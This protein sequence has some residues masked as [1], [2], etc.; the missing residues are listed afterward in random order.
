MAEHD[1]T[2]GDSVAYFSP[3]GRSC[4]Y[5]AT[6]GAAGGFTP[7]VVKGSVYGFVVTGTDAAGNYIAYTSAGDGTAWLPT[8]SRGTSHGISHQ[9]AGYREIWH[10]RFGGGPFRKRTRELREPRRTAYPTGC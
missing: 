5:S 1:G 3:N 7:Q 9:R 2:A 8:G 10:V 4:Q 6:L